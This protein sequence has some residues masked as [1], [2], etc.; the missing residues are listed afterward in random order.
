MG[1]NGRDFNTGS[2]NAADRREVDRR[3]RQGR[4]CP[5]LEGYE[6]VDP[7]KLAAG[8]PAEEFVVQ[9]NRQVRQAGATTANDATVRAFKAKAECD[10]FTFVFGVLDQWWL[11]P[12]LHRAVCDWLQRVPPYRKCLVMPRGHAKSTLI[13]QGLPLHMLIQPASANVYFPGLAGSDTRILMCGEKIDR[14]KDH[15]RVIS[16]QL[17]TNA[18]LRALWPDVMWENPKRQSRKWN[19]EE[20]I[21][22]RKREWPDPTLR[23][24]GVGGAITGAHPNCL[25]K[26]DI[27]TE[28]AANSPT[29][30]QA[31]IRWHEN[32]RALL[33]SQGAT[34]LEF[35]TG[36]RWAVGDLVDHIETNDPTVE[37][38]TDWREIVV[39]GELIYPVNSRDQYTDFGKP[40]A[41]EQ[42]Q[43]QHGAM[44]WL[45]YMNSV[46]DSN[47]VDFNEA[48]LR[49]FELR[50]GVLWFTEDDRDRETAR[51]MRGM[52]AND[53]AGIPNGGRGM[54]LNDYLDACERERQTS[55][56]GGRRLAY[57]R[58]AR[59][60]EAAPYADDL[61]KR[62]RGE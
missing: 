47:L 53:A 2:F 40:G 1:R 51:V 62:E 23:A 9:K 59:R 7:L 57:I 42:L 56:I 30:M 21:V 15:L 4:A 34:A 31:A 29:V 18:L 35:I 54:K 44:F 60:G 50:D 58:G 48:D 5:G 41:I 32:A 33:A 17:T 38:N 16:D 14:S 55:T 10:L 24:I 22:R 43:R 26:D 25:I 39:G 11:Y 20:L 61:N 6:T 52:T 45:L 36:T 19:D 46:G 12:P 3:R 13:G 49:G 27:T 8:R 28:A 37:V